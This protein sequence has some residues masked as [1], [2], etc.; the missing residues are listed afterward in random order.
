MKVF[1]INGMPRAGKDTFVEM[2]Q[3]QA[4]WC[5][6]V[7]TVDFVKELAVRCGW[8]GTKT[9]ENRAFLSDLKDLLTKWNNVP[10]NM[11]R[12]RIFLFEKQIEQ[13]DFNSNDGV[14]FIHCREPEEIQKFVEYY[15][16]QTILVRR[17]AIE[18]KEQSNHADSE[19]FNYKY[20]IH[21]NNNG[22]LEDL[23]KVAIQFLEQQ[24]VKMK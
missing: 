17:E 5:L 14:V 22:T 13:Y 23:E 15:N 6:N 21:I 9:P 2:C 4:L 16:A 19:V 24:G 18:T 1:V 3:I 20:D 10:F 12:Q 11:V 7:S 8:D